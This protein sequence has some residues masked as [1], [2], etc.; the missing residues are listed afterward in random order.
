[1][2]LF[3]SAS[4]PKWKGF[5]VLS[6][7]RLALLRA[8]VRKMKVPNLHIGAATG[9]R[10]FLLIGVALGTWEARLELFTERLENLGK[11]A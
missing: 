7:D 4:T 3:W 6:G 9:V 1:M 2:L 10:C 11:G 8:Y 5:E